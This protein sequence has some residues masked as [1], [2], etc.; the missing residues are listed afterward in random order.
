[1][2]E[3]EGHP[4]KA[5]KKKEDILAAQQEV[6]DLQKSYVEARKKLLK[7]SNDDKVQLVHKKETAQ[8]G[9]TLP[10][11]H[12]FREEFKLYGSIGMPGQKEKLT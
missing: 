2:P 8:P 1:M 4:E 5:K 10:V 6:E 3:L 9:A 12:L 11:N 7:L